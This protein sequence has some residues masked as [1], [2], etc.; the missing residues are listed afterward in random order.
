[1]VINEINY[2]SSDDFDPGDWIEIYNPNE[3]SIN[4]SNWVLKDD[5]D[6]NTFVFAEGLTIEAD[7]FIV[8]VRKSDDFEESFS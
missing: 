4:L 3:S 8:V 7:G 1:M 5:N 6:S 2:K